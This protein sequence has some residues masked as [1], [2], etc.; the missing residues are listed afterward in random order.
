MSLLPSNTP[1]FLRDLALR[2]TDYF[3]RLG[4]NVLADQLEEIEAAHSRR[5]PAPPSPSVSSGWRD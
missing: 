2:T 5:N 1:E 4:L 3:D